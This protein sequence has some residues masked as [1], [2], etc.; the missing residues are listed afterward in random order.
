MDTR[1]MYGLGSNPPYSLYRNEEGKWG[2]VDGSG[3]RLPACFETKDEK[4]FSRVPWEVVMFDEKDGFSVIAWYDPSEV[5]FNFT[6]DNPAYPE[7]YEHYLWEKEDNRIKEFADI[8]YRLI[9]ESDHWLVEDLLQAR[10]V[11]ALDDEE[12]YDH[13]DSMIIEHPEV[14]DP[15]KTTAILEPVMGNEEV[16]D[17]V[18]KALWTEKVSLDSMIKVFKEEFPDGY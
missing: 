14:E 11:Y 1:S 10:E 7:K 12:H 18:K 2:L 13:I 9:P 17:A 5:W 6:F 4:T 8:L 15:S 16:D 3:M